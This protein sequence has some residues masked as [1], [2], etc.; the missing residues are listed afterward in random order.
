MAE[1]HQYFATPVVTDQLDDAASLNEALAASILAQR[2]ADAG[3]KLSNRGGWHSRRDFPT[4]AGEAGQRL[5]KHALQLANAFVVPRK[6]AQVEWAVDA[7]ANASERGN[8]NAPHVHSGTYWSVVYYVQV[9]DG[10]GGELILHDPRMPGLRMH[11]PHLRFKDNGP[12]GRIK[13]QPRA[14]EMILFPAWLWHSV[15]PWD[16][17]GTRISVAMNI[18]AVQAQ[19]RFAIR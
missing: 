6:G 15:E 14:G 2:D 1:L 5:M 7:W 18:R 12:E 3:L 11:A 19:S 4:W 8:L 13:I 16:G 17:E 9:G 10:E